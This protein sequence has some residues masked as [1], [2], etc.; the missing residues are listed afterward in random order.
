MAATLPTVIDARQGERS[1]LT[2][3]GCC[4]AAEEQRGVH[5]NA[6]RVGRSMSFV[7]WLFPAQAVRQALEK[8][9]PWDTLS[10]WR[11]SK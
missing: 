5:P 3:R 6:A 2:A 11:G 1:R 10:V 4:A 9:I 8:H 7:R